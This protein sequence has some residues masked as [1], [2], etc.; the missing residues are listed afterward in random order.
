MKQCELNVLY[1]DIKIIFLNC[2]PGYITKLK[3]VPR[4]GKTCLIFSSIRT[5]EDVEYLIW[6]DDNS[7]W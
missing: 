4:E 2:S 1:N 7:H 6:G 5:L 3:A